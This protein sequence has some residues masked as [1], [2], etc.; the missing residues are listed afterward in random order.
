MKKWVHFNLFVLS[1]IIGIIGTFNYIM[2]PLWCFAHK[3]VLQSNREGFEERQQK[4][5]L[6]HFQPFQYDG[7]I[8]GS[9]RVTVHNATTV[10]ATRLFNM[11]A[12]G[13]QPYEFNDYIEYAKQ[14]N[15]HSFNYIILGLDFL[16]IEQHRQEYYIE[17]Y[18]RNT[19]SLLYRYKTLFSFDSLEISIKNLKNT[20]FGRAKKRFKTYNQD[21]IAFAL[22]KD[23]QLVENK[24]STYL[25]S[26]HNKT[27]RY[28]RTNYLKTLQEL[29]K[30]NPD[31]IFIVFTTPLPEPVLTSLF[32]NKAN[33]ETYKQWINDISTLYGS[34]YNFC[35]VNSITQN[36]QTHFVDEGH[37]ISDVGNCIN[38]K[39]MGNE[40]SAPEYKDFGLLINNDPLKNIDPKGR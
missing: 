29:K 23:N 2:D 35:Y 15:G 11:A 26:L 4:I 20:F 37:Y 7:I 38:L 39:I 31:A 19:N 22:P 27:I 32:E 17:P 40:C 25:T 36:Y 14:K 34:F 21:H 18:I 10:K 33:Q 13:M 1:I 24:I 6:I 28:D 8:L 12:D 30:N 3:N 16:A 5:N 9:S